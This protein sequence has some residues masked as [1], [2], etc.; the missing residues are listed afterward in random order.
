MD[1][2]E[3]HNTLVAREAMAPDSELARHLA[4]CP[5]CAAVM[6]TREQQ[7]ALVT[8]EDGALLRDHVPPGVITVSAKR[9]GY[10]LTGMPP[11]VQVTSGQVT[12]VVIRLTRG[13]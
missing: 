9:A 6:A 4:D 1:C 3:I 5:V 10:K 2:N 11:T 8:G 7:A 12:N 13:D